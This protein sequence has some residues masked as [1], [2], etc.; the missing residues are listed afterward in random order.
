VAEQQQLIPQ[1]VIS[2]SGRRGAVALQELQTR[3]HY[4]SQDEG[5]SRKYVISDFG[6]K[7]NK[8]LML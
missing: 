4:L 8:F 7:L 5:P 1:P 2:R 6:G 3:T